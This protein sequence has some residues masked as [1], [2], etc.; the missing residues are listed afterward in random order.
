MTGLLSLKNVRQPQRADQSG[1]ES[2]AAGGMGGEML[3]TREERTEWDEDDIT[4]FFLG[5]HACCS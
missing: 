4:P 2:A 3:D 1:R 5:K